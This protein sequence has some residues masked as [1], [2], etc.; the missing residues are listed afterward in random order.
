MRTD[1]SGQR[2]W[3][4]VYHTLTSLTCHT[5]G[6]HGIDSRCCSYLLNG[7]SEVGPHG[8]QFSLYEL[9][10]PNISVHFI[11]KQTTLYELLSLIHI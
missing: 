10:E 6:M 3:L 4:S 8:S 7:I 11:D 5:A 2:R 9:P 1:R